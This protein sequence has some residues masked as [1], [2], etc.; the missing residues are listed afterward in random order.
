[1]DLPFEELAQLV[2]LFC[3]EVFVVEQR[4]LLCGEAGEDLLGE[5]LVQTVPLIEQLLAAGVE[6]LP[7]AATVDRQFARLLQHLPLE[8]A[9]AL[10][11]E[12]V[13]QHAGDA[14]ELDTL[15]QRQFGVFDE[16]DDATGKAQPAQF[17]VEIGLGRPGSD[18]CGR[19]GFSGIGVGKRTRL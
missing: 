9:D 14:G 1:L 17:P 12:L 13:V 5:Y 10:H 4:K 15:E 11:E 18:Q 19:V 16:C 8:P 6:L 7:G 3:V 2:A